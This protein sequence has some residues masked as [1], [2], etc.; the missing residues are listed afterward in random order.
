MP[1]ANHQAIVRFDEIFS[2]YQ[3]NIGWTWNY[4]WTIFEIEIHRTFSS[5]L[6]IPQFRQGLI[7]ILSRL[8]RLLAG[9]G[10]DGLAIRWTERKMDT[11]SRIRP[12]MTFKARPQNLDYLPS[13]SFGRKKEKCEKDKVL[14]L[15][16]LFFFSTKSCRKYIYILIFLRLELFRHSAASYYQEE[17]NCN[18]LT[19]CLKAI[20]FCMKTNSMRHETN[21]TCLREDLKTTEIGTNEEHACH[22]KMGHYVTLINNKKVCSFMSI[23]Y[24]NV[25]FQIKLF[26]E[27]LMLLLELYNDSASVLFPSLNIFRITSEQWTAAVF[28]LFLFSTIFNLL[29]NNVW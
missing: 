4:L 3:W 10:N 24:Q 16:T 22:R 28:F 19:I 17:P 11:L 21:T 18:I 15:F 7:K 23:W 29:E 20:K 25:I 26:I 1:S 9:H 5:D 27:E 14:T 6:S 13:T 2:K 8:I 12:P